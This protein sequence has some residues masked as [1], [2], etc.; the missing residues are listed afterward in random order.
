MRTH[1][2]DLACSGRSHS[3]LSFLVAYAFQRD[4][5]ENWLGDSSNTRCCT[6]GG[7]EGWEWQPPNP[8]LPEHRLTGALTWQIPVGRDRAFLVEHAGR[9]RLRRRRLAVHDGRAYLLGSPG[10][11]Q[12]RLAVSGNPKLDNPTRERWFDTSLFAAQPAFTP[13]TNPAFYDGLNGPG[14]WFVDMTLT[15]SF[16]IGRYRL[17][18]R[19]EAYNAFNHIVWDQPDIAFGSANFGKVTRKRIDSLGREIQVGLR[20]VF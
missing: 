15:K 16:P 11:L 4:R 7:E 8:S 18:A 10:A 14:A 9:A 19:I 6:T 20:F 5:I 1:S 2:F 13:R 17:E 12:Q 3:G